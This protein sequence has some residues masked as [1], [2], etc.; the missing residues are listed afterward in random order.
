MVA[1]SLLD[2]ALKHPLSLGETVSSELH[3]LNALPVPAPL[4]D[5]VELALVGVERVVG[6]FVGPVVA[7]FRAVQNAYMIAR[8]GATCVELEI[9]AMKSKEAIDQLGKYKR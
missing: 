4:P 7:H 8:D 3:F 2:E 9:A 5:L 6:F 1:W